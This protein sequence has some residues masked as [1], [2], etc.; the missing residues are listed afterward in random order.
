MKLCK[1]SEFIR[2]TRSVCPVCLVTLPADIVR[3]RDKGDNGDKCEEIIL[4]KTCPEHGQFEAV[5]WRGKP[6]FDKWTRPKS[7]IKELL[8]QSDNNKDCPHN[9]G[10][11][12]EHTQRSCTVLLEL[13]K[14]CN[15]HCPICFANS[16]LEH[17]KNKDFL[18]LEQLIQK[19]EWIY[20]Q[21]GSIVLQLSGGEPTL[22]PNLIEL[23]KA[24]SKL[25]PAVQL[26]TNGLL[27]AKDADMAKNLKKAGLSW[28]FLQFDGSNDDIYLKLRG[29]K[30]LQQKLLAIENCKKA[31]LSVVLVPTVVAGINDNDLGQILK[32]ALS[33]SPVVRGLHLQPMTFSGRNLFKD[34]VTALTLP[35]VLCKLS[36][37]SN[38]QIKLEH[39]SPPGCEHERCS[40][41]CRYHID[42]NGNMTVVKGNDECCC[43]NKPVISAAEGA[44]KSIESVIRSWQGSEGAEQQQSDENLGKSLGENL[45]QGSGQKADIKSLDAFDAF[46]AKAKNNVFSI[47][48]MAFQDALNIDLER[49]Q[50]CCVHVYAENNK[51]IPFCAYNLTSLDNIPLYRS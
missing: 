34:K 32:I 40:F 8:R 50:G 31:G 39:A 2:K 3:Q 41:H 49:L 21:A 43:D 46:I 17:G 7:A 23:V 11:C 38:G 24:G 9:C 30:L 18:P 42:N 14:Q 47:T 29:Q 48:C 26:N 45:G 4:C 27:L 10:L 12:I 36:E 6:E 51:L 16:S 35:E 1:D 44:E 20:A 13:T 33:L 22:Y 25:F 19:L 28:V 37:Q 15:L 5:I